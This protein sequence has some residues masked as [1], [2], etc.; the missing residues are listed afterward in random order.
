MMLSLVFAA[1]LSA[2]FDV[3]VGKVRPE[4]HSSGFGPT[5]CSQ[6]EQDLNDVKSMGFKAA[7]THLWSADDA[8]FRP[9]D[10][11]TRSFLPADALGFSLLQDPDLP[12]AIR[13]AA[14]ATALGPRYRSQVN[15]GLTSVARDD[16][17][18]KITRSERYQGNDSWNGMVWTLINVRV[19]DGLL[20]CGRVADAV[21]L[22]KDTVRM[23]EAEDD[24]YEFYDPMDGKGCGV[25][26]YA[27]TAAD[28]LQLVLGR[29]LGISYDGF[30]RTLTVRPRIAED[31]CV[32]GVDVPGKGRATIRQVGGVVTCAFTQ[33]GPKG[34]SDADAGRVAS[35]D[36]SLKQ[37]KE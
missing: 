7:R 20:T 35:P 28:Y 18:Y 16:A 13:D 25:K 30:T 4:L 17:R 5:I 15:F 23:L 10:V 24:F 11:R 26:G 12:D 8:Q 34:G 1:A 6:T 9:R 21:A 22:A 33:S 2:N 36:G 31:F 37:Q 27:W 14:W 32:T 29:L 3:E 19:I